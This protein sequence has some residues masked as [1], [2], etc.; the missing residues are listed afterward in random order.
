MAGK[1]AAG[2]ATVDDPD[3]ETG[4]PEAADAPL[5][6]LHRLQLDDFHARQLVERLTDKVAKLERH[7]EGAR[8]SLADAEE[9]ADAAAQALDEHRDFMDDEDGQDPE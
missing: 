2:K 1:S 9:Q 3:V 6:E 8:E 5:R 4:P 7:L